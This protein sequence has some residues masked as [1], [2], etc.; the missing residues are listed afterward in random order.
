MNK[1]LRKQSLSPSRLCRLILHK[2]LG[3][4][5][6]CTLII[7]IIIGPLLWAE[8]PYRYPRAIEDPLRRQNSLVLAIDD[9]LEQKKSKVRDIY[10]EYAVRGTTVHTAS[11]R[12]MLDSGI[13]K[14]AGLTD[15]NQAWRCFI[16]NDD[17][18][19]LKFNN[20]GGA[21]IGV[22]FE[23]AKCL[24]ARLEDFG[25]KRQQFMVVG[26][27]R[28][29]AQ[30]EGTRAWKYGWQEKAVN[31][32]SA[33]DHLARWLD[34]VTAIINLP[35]IMDDNIIQLRGAL[36]NLSL[37]LLKSPARLYINRGDPFIAEIYDLPQIRGKVRLHIGNG[38]RILYYGGPT[39]R[40][41]YIRENR[42]LIFSRDPVALDRAVLELIIRARRDQILP[43]NAP[44]ALSVPYLDTAYAM[45]I[46][47]NDLNFIDYRQ[48][49]LEKW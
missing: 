42:T 33:C 17:I 49:K 41:R 25:F 19:A 7:L 26:I 15:P 32:G 39:V 5:G 35:N 20:I 38:L 31:F 27:D 37:P 9:P 14:L 29:N 4:P 24:L 28:W 44:I 6:L 46:G 34:E 30:E 47:Y 3:W 1:Y 12:A 22:N 43:E 36:A 21:E 23:L 13:T 18:I 40:Q 8:A 10:G 48:I 11:I 2:P 16:H 45:G